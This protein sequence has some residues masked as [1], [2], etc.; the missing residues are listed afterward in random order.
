MIAKE[1]LGESTRSQKR[2]VQLEL[3]PTMYALLT[4]L[5]GTTGAANRGE[6]LRRAIGIFN[7]L[8]KA[9]AECKRV[10]LESADGSERER[11]IIVP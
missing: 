1:Q 4:Q 9:D 7:I 11:L 6:V 2:R 5:V 8:V 10:M 3:T